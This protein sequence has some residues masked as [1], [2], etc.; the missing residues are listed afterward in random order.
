ML[1]LLAFLTAAVMFG[2]VTNAA[3]VTAPIVIFAFGPFA[4]R[5]VNGSSTIA[6]GLAGQMIAKHPVIVEVM[7]VRWGEPQARV[8]KTIAAH[9]PILVLGLGE[10]HPNRIAVETTAKNA[11]A[12]R[13]ELGKKPPAK[14]V[15]A[16][17]PESRKY[18]LSFAEDWFKGSDI[19][20]VSSDDAGAYL[21]NSLFYTV[22]GQSI[23]K[24]GFVHL[25]PQEKMTDEEYRKLI[26]PK[27]V[28]L[29][30]KNLT[31]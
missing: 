17:G 14:V 10:G 5:S 9:K 22:L 31:D 20:V 4:G 25:P 16:D 28:M 13:D 27:I 15:E 3:E 1:K 6:N 8:A 26:A 30:E 23:A 24:A 29:L 11:A 19:A 2:P 21:C 12:S 18:R 7:P